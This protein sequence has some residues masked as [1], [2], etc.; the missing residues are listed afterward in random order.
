MSSASFIRT[1]VCVF[2]HSYI[3]VA[4]R[5]RCLLF[6]GADKV[7]PRLKRRYHAHLEKVKEHL[8]TVKDFDKLISPQSLFHHFLGPEPSTKVRKNIKIVK[9]SKYA[10]LFLMRKLS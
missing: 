4:F 8:E 9:K 2:L 7:R 10:H 1:R 3:F 6:F 5:I